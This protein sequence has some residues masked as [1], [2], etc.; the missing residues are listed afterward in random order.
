MAKL[1]RDIEGCSG[2]A[3]FPLRFKA[4]T[5]CPVDLLEAAI[6]LEAVDPKAAEA[7]LKKA[8]Q[9][10]RADEDAAQADAKGGAD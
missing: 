2:G 9:Q 6:A 3:V 10:R 7:E 8:A 5:D 1:L 4:G